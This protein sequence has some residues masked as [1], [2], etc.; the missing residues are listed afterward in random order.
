MPVS[1]P[2]SSSQGTKNTAEMD[3]LRE[4]P[5]LFLRNNLAAELLH[6]PPK[7]AGVEQPVAC[8]CSEKRAPPRPGYFSGDHNRTA[9]SPALTSVLPSGENATVQTCSV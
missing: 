2:C 3:T 5:T 6:L 8:P 1:N 4:P 9:S 7:A